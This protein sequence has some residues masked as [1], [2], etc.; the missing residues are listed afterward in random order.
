MDLTRALK[1]YAKRQ[2]AELLG[3]STI[4]S[5]LLI[6]RRAGDG[7]RVIASPGGG[8]GERLHERALRLLPGARSVIVYGVAL[9]RTSIE[10]LPATMNEYD[11]AFLAA[12]AELYRIGLRLCRWLEGRERRAVSVPIEGRSPAGARYIDGEFRGDI[13]FKHYA[14]ASGLGTFGLSGWIIT[15]EYGAR[16]RFGGVVS[17]AE[18]RGGR[19]LEGELC[20]L[21]RACV[22]ACPARAIRSPGL[23][24]IVVKREACYHQMFHVLGG[25]RCGLCLRACLLD[26]YGPGKGE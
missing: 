21:C 16:V 12:N 4:D 8:E 1:G 11:A 7:T 5:S 14:E 10:G 17:D 19:P 26:G 6:R 15:P 18:L 23:E 22:K 2:G 13:S 25:K 20:T 3:I 24:E 9:P